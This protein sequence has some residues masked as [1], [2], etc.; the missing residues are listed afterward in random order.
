MSQK[1]LNK[2]K[3]KIGDY[4]KYKQLDN[5]NNINK[6]IY[7]DEKTFVW[8][9]NGLAPI[10]S[11]VKKEKNR[12]IEIV[13]KSGSK[14]KVAE[15][16][17]FPQK[18]GSNIYA[19]DSH[20]IMT[21][22]GIDKIVSK[23]FVEENYV[24]DISIPSPHVYYCSEGILHHNTSAKSFISTNLLLNKENVLFLSLEMPE[25][26]ITRKFDANLWGVTM[27]ELETMDSETLKSKAKNVEHLIANLTIKD[28]AAGTFSTIQLKSLLD[29]LK[30]KKD[31]VPDAVVIDYLGLMYSPRASKGA[32]EYE[33]LGKVSE[34]LHGIAKNTYNSKGE[35]GIKVITSTQLNR[36]SDGNTEAGMSAV[37]DSIKIMQTAD[38][39]ILLLSN[40][41]MKGENQQYWKIVKNRNNGR[42]TGH[43]VGTDFGRVQYKDLSDDTSGSYTANQ[44]LNNINLDET[45]KDLNFDNFN[46]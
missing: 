44:E 11:M 25:M 40:P 41:A 31:F 28:Y 13:T 2:V 23:E 16:H 45:N 24:Y 32:K 6:T 29:E 37:S 46:F 42:L 26:E 9:P 10:L 38:I 19:I 14:I 20:Y 8:T 39:S 1:T 4:F 36:S 15:N 34:D 30:S 17:I 43:L 21:V 3:I 5:L 27:D 22:D 33:I 18:D 12:I 35:K 7:Q